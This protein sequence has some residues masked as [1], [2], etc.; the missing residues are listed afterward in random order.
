VSS[1]GIEHEAKFMLGD[2]RDMESRLR[3]L[4]RLCTPWHFESNTVYDRD[5]E[6]AASGRLLRLRRALTCTLT[7]KEPAPGQKKDGIKSRIERETTVQDPHA[8]DAIL[9]ALGYAPRLRYEKFRAVWELPQSH[10]FL[11]ILPF[12]HFLEIEAE[13]QSI[14]DIAQAIGLDPDSAMDKSYHSLHRS[15]RRRQGLAPLEDFVFD[16]AQHHLL[17]TRLGILPR[18]QGDIYAD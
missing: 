12:G 18:P 17:T 9:R 1:P 11:D 6:L 7:F 8:M 2:C 3:S 5:G 10:V 16:E 15:W 13:P 14:S 4:G